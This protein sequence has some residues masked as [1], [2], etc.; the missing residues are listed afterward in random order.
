MLGDEDGIE[1]LKELLL[2]QQ[3]IPVIMITSRSTDKH[4][5]T[6]IETGVNH[7]MVKPFDEDEL[8]EQMNSLLEK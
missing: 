2:L 1:I 4:R 5:I 7:Y 3:N 8:A 6:A